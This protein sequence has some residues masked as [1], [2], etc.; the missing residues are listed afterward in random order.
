[1][2]LEPLDAEELLADGLFAVP[3]RS[4]RRAPERADGSPTSIWPSGRERP[5]RGETGRTVTRGWRCGDGRLD[6]RCCTVQHAYGCRLAPTLLEA[7]VRPA[8]SPL[9]RDGT[10]GT[11]RRS[12]VLN[13]AAVEV[14]GQVLGRYLCALLDPVLPP[15]DR[16]EPARH[17]VR[18]DAAG[19]GRNAPACP[20]RGDDEHC[21]ARVCE[22]RRHVP[23][24]RFTRPHWP[25]ASTTTG[26][27]TK[28]VTVARKPLSGGKAQALSSPQA[29]WRRSSR[30]QLRPAAPSPPIEACD[31]PFPASADGCGHGRS[32]GRGRRGKPCR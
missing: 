13:D 20:V 2:L 9:A 31:P 7:G 15:A 30:C 8:R 29:P 23:S 21:A 3:W 27:H 22:P 16:A 10:Q 5:A 32:S 24:S 17:G 14:R 28:L 6:G 18:P 12:G 1:M 25:A 19:A 4:R 26:R 11:G